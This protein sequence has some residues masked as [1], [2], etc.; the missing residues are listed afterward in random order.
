MPRIGITALIA[1]VCSAMRGGATLEQA[2]ARQSSVVG[3]TYGR[4][5]EPRIREIIAERAQPQERG[6]HVAQVAADV[7]A[8]ARVSELLGCPAVRCLEAVGAAY[9][10]S[11]L[12]DDLRSQAFAVPRATVRL[13]TA[14][15]VVTVM[16]G[17]LLGAR[18]LAFLFGSPQGLLCLAL[19]LCWYAGGLAWMRAMLRGMDGA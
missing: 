2:F 7:R 14:L 15:P 4:L 11:R 3:H 17:E 6:A 12:L 9:R 1:S 16:L 13:L 5:S 10:R 18:P 19:G 8:A